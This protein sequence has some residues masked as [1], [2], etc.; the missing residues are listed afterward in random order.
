MSIK[1]T[2]LIATLLI[3]TGLVAAWRPSTSSERTIPAPPDAATRANVRDVTTVLTGHPNEARKLATFYHEAAETIR[4]D[5]QGAKI[6]KTT[7][8]LRTFCQRTVTL[9]FQGDFAKVPGLADAIHGPKGALAR[10]LQLEVTELDPIQAA[11]GLDAVAWACE[12]ATR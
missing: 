5:G 1:P 8:D 10:L 4:R 6:I 3:V 11:N 2:T 7:A 9:R 12:E